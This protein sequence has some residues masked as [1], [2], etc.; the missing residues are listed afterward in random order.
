MDHGP[1]DD[2]DVIVLWHI[3]SKRN[4][5]G[6]TEDSIQGYDVVN[7]ANLK[8]TL[9]T[10]INGSERFSKVMELKKSKPSKYPVF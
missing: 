8:R 3:L 7:R 9:L 2:A 6:I 1:R 5:S 4:F 10:E